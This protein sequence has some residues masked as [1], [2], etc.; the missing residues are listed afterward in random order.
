MWDVQASGAPPPP[1]LLSAMKD[2]GLGMMGRR[3]EKEWA[4]FYTLDLC[5]VS[6][7]LVINSHG[8]SWKGSRFLSYFLKTCLNLCAIETYCRQVGFCFFLLHLCVKNSRVFELIFLQVLTWLGSIWFQELSPDRYDDGFA[9]TCTVERETVPPPL[10]GW[11]L[12]CRWV[13]FKQ[14]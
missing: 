6:F 11:V 5:W 9:Y 4:L 1:L 10:H 13:A 2:V 7:H 8:P 14:T 12:G 3:N